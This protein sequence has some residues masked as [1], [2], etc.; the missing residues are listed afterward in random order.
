MITDVAQFF[1]DGCGRCARHAT[2]DCGARRHAGALAAARRLCLDAGLEEA[3][4][5]GHPCYAHAGRN[6][7][8]LGAHREGARLTFFHAAL[9]RDPAGVLERKGPNARHPDAVRFADAGAVAAMA[10]PVTALLRQAMIHAEAGT[11]APR[12]DRPLDLP[13]ELSDA[14]AADTELAAAF[15]ALTPGRRRSH[16]IVIGGAKKPETRRARIARL[17]PRIMAG[18]GA[19]ERP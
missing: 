4:K 16:A 18:Q 2:P 9:L 19:N 11:R 12:E 13:D 1:A 17:R 7:A 3:A 14:L 8:I 10:G 15:E 5:W 6:V